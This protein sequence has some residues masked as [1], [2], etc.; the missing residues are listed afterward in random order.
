M[1][2][3]IRLLFVASL[4]TIA[5]TSCS[6]GA[7]FEDELINKIKALPS[8]KEIN[9]IEMK[10][11]FFKSG[12]EVFFEIPLDW[13]NVDG[14][15]IKQRVIIDAKSFDVSTVVELQGYSLGE[16][17]ISNNYTRELP[18]L[19]DGNFVAIE[20][21]FFAK[22]SY[23]KATYD[24]ASGWEQ[25]T[26]KNAAHDHNF[27]ISEL[28]KVFTKKWVATG[29]SKGG[30]ITNCLA[31]LYPNT[32]D[33]YVPYVAPCLT[34]YDSRPSDFINNEAGD[35]TYGKEQGKV[36]RD[37][38]LK[39]QVF[40]FEHKQPIMDALY[41]V[42]DSSN[43]KFRDSLTRENFYDINLLD[44]SY[45]L[46]QYQNIE[47]KVINDFLALPESTQ[48]ELESKINNA[49]KVLLDAGNGMDNVSYNSSTFPY[50]I[51]AHKEMGNYT[52][53]FSYVKAMAES[54]GKNIT[55]SIPEGKEIELTDKVYLCDDQI[56]N[57]HYDQTMYDT[58]TSWIKDEN[59]DTKIIMINGQEDP[60]FH[61]SLPLKNNIG[62]NVKV[63]THPT[64][65]HRVQIT[66][67][68]QEIQTEILN[69]LNTWLS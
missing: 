32:C 45:G 14:E 48:D 50:Y 27:I 57:I 63:Y 20:H 34:Q 25:L 5:A 39:F 44:F 13:N 21:R 47:M 15:K 55:I 62:K 51:T 30:Y 40:C 54:L 43:W 28:R 22:S 6:S 37:N 24:K 42:E 1:K 2:K 10:D 38:I 65:N 61:G 11:T 31:C 56:K 17:Y 69:T 33:A 9:K 18:K 59:L 64:S 19:I 29:A 23:L 58:L 7:T 60:W 36:V 67:F 68:S 26:V 12:L 46:W 52:Y 4:T 8:V 49:I 16:K 41:S 53:N 3:I 66:S 35:S